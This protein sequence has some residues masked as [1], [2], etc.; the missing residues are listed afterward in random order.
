M[1]WRSQN[2]TVFQKVLIN[3]ISPNAVHGVNYVIKSQADR[4]TKQQSNLHVR[5]PLVSDHLPYATT[6]PKH[7]FLFSV[8]AL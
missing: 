8:K 7:L 6:Y 2:N 3:R 5:P 4:V 1:I